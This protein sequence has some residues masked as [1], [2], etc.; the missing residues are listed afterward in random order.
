MANVSLTSSNAVR[1]KG[2]QTLLTIETQQNETKAAKFSKELPVSTTALLL[3]SSQEVQYSWTSVMLFQQL[4]KH[5]ELTIVPGIFLSIENTMWQNISFVLLQWS[6]YLRRYI[7]LQLHHRLVIAFYGN[8]I[9]ETTHSRLVSAVVSFSQIGGDAVIH[10]TDWSVVSIFSCIVL[11]L[12]Q[13]W[14]VYQWARCCDMIATQWHHRED[15][16]FGLL[17]SALD[18]KTKQNNNL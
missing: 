16:S 5:P 13:L 4:Q 10:N 3:L 12:Q 1:N 8:G 17:V 11:A 2:C 14:A 9:L 6:M 18:E 15:G 7:L